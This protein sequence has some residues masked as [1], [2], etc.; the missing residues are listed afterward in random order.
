MLDNKRYEN[1]P[2]RNSHMLVGVSLIT[3]AQSLEIE[4]RARV[5]HCEIWMDDNPA[6]S[7]RFTGN[8]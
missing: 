7:G 3:F 2:K 1:S 8:W 4:E 5:S 6:N